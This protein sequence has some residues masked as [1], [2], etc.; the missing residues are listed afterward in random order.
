MSDLVVV[1]VKSLPV[2]SDEEIQGAIELVIEDKNTMVAVDN[3]IREI[4]DRVKVIDNF[5]DEG[6][7]KKGVWRVLKTALDD[8]KTQW[9]AFVKKPKQLLSIYDRKQKEFIRLENEKKREQEERIRQQLREQ[10]EAKKEERIV[11]LVESGDIEAAKKL[12][13]TEVKTPVVNLK[14]EANI[15]NQYTRKNWKFRIIDITKLPDEYL[16]KIP[17]EDKIG[18][19]VKKL[20]AE[21]N[22]PGVEA[23]NDFAIIRK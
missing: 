13:D 2:T 22:I 17:D 7:G 18:A 3:R 10:E 6:K 12:V 19:V 16:K 1:D 8:T 15:D 5:Y 21:S 11:E 9:D 4:N 20:E 23:Y 14:T